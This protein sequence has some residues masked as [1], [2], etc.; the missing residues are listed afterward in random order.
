MARQEEAEAGSESRPFC[1]FYFE[2]FASA[3]FGLYPSGWTANFGV[4][5]A[6]RSRLLRLPLVVALR[7]LMRSNC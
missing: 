5:R 3:A 7:F 4:P 1:F 6:R 2:R